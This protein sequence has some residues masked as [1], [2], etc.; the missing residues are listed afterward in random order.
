M[1]KSS[2]SLVAVG[3]VSNFIK[4]ESNGVLT[5]WERFCAVSWC[6]L[7]VSSEDEFV[8]RWGVG[9]CGLGVSIGVG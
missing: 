6:S 1:N 7:T 8:K 3:D 4:A 5:G 9:S 2:E